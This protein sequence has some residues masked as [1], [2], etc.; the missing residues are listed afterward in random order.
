MFVYLRRAAAKLSEFGPSK[1][2]VGSSS[3]KIPQ[4]RQKVSA[5]ANLII[6]EART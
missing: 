4:F 5:R 3:A 2:V 1:F 6:S